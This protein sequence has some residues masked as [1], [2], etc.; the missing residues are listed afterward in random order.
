MF[1]GLAFFTLLS[2]SVS[3]VIFAAE[4]SIDTPVLVLDSLEEIKN[5]FLQTNVDLDA[6]KKLLLEKKLNANQ[7]LEIVTNQMSPKDGPGHSTYFTFSASKQKELIELALENGAK[8]SDITINY[9][10][11]S[12]MPSLNTAKLMLEN[13][14][15]SLD[16]SKFLNM[17]LGSYL[18][19]LDCKEDNPVSAPY[20]ELTLEL[21]SLAFDKGADANKIDKFNSL[22]SPSLSKLL[23]ERMDPGHFLSLVLQMY[24]EKY[25]IE[26]NAPEIDNERI[27]YRDKLVNLALEKNAD[28][29]KIDEFYHLPSIEL[30]NLLLERGLNPSKFLYLVFVVNTEKYNYEKKSFEIDNELIMQKNIL[31]KLALD[32]GGSFQAIFTPIERLIKEEYEKSFGE[33]ESLDPNELLTEILLSYHE[34]YESTKIVFKDSDK[35][36]LTKLKDALVKL[37]LEYGAN[38]SHPELSCEKAFL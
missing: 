7:L 37:A 29:Q 12:N 38:P 19:C 11:R 20:E 13:P 23:L 25:N 24:C 26:K 4:S 31:I 8:F 36:E 3:H 2:L 33:K 16:P 22:P 28:P 9:G 27:A 17:I 35:A 10:Y 14:G 18:Y 6:V 15:N 34:I 32:K 5:I 1:L 30:S 21:V